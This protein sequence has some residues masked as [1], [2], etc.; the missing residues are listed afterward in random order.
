[1]T[2]TTK[3]STLPAPPINLSESPILLEL[4]EDITLGFLADV[5]APDGSPNTLK[6]MISEH[7]DRY[8]NV[9][10]PP[11]D[12]VTVK[13]RKL[14]KI[15]SELVELDSNM[16]VN[17]AHRPRVRPFAELAEILVTDF[18]I[19]LFKRAHE[20][21]EEQGLRLIAFRPDLPEQRMIDQANERAATYK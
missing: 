18:M 7:M 11:A 5:Q 19:E 12:P 8:F 1:M 14:S 9:S 17:S 4:Y 3:R 20:L 10:F 21:I 15:L 6:H 16:W 13:K 2:R